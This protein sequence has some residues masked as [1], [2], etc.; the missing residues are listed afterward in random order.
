MGTG[1]EGR[2]YINPREDGDHE[3]VAME[4]VDMYLGI[5]TDL[6]QYR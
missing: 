6:V 5:V 4:D 2:S 1:R 3:I